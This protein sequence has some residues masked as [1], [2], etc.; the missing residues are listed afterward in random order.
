ML[1]RRQGEVLGYVQASDERS[2]EAAAVKTFKL[3]DQQRTRLVV[4]EM[5]E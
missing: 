1:L 5:A 3:S 2:A 4:N